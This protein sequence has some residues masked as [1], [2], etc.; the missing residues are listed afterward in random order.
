VLEPEFTVSPACLIAGEP[1]QFI[2]RSEGFPIR[3]LWKFGNGRTSSERSPRGSYEQPGRYVVTLELFDGVQTR[4]TSR[5]ITVN[6]NF[7]LVPHADFASPCCAAV[8]IARELQNLSSSDATS[9]RW[10]FGD[11]QTSTDKNPRHAW[12]QPGM[13]MIRLIA[14][15]EHG[16]HQLGRSIHVDDVATPPTA[17]FL[18]E[19]AAN[20]GVGQPVVFTNGSS[21]NAVAFAGP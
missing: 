11:G 5:T 15:N 17:D 2:D 3:W 9:F 20:I 10:D 12:S 13:Y 18:W 6:P 14:A 4:E 1:M 16:E 21:S 19:P 8:G 7:Q